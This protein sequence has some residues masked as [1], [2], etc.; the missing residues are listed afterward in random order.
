MT[1]GQ[2]QQPMLIDSHAH[3]THPRLAGDLHEVLVRAAEAGVGAIVTVGYDAASNREVARIV[4]ERPGLVGAVGI[5]PHDARTAS[6]EVL[7]EM[8]RLSAGERIVAIGEMGLD[9]YRDL[10]PRDAQEMAFI[11]QIHLARE[12]G[13]PV[14]VHTREAQEETLGI[15]QRE[16]EGELRGVMHCFSG[17]LDFA[18]QCTDLGLYIGIAGNVTYPKAKT[19]QTVA[20]EVPLERLLV[21]TDCPWLA[22]QE[23]RGKRN[24]PAY[25]RLVAEKV[26]ELRGTSFDELAEAT[27]RNARELFTLEVER[28]V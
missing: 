7:E 17:D 6:A 4:D 18:R 14:I 25:L 10:S 15:L 2:A 8:A 13:L 5:H 22:P 28:L 20:A 12:L 26:A 9:F 21:E 23:H 19:V 11:E 1:E 3:V 24:E 27:S 16:G